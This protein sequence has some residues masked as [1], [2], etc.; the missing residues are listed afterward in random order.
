M[1]KRMMALMFCI[2]AFGFSSAAQTTV[3]TTGGASGYIPVFTGTA[4]ITSSGI[5]YSSGNVGIG[6]TAPAAPLE[7]VANPTSTVPQVR[8]SPLGETGSSTSIPSYLDFYSTFDAYPSDQGPR[9]TATIKAQYSGGTW[10]NEALVFEV[11]TGSVNDA[12]NEPTERMRIAGNGNVGICT[13]APGATLEVNGSAKVDGNVT[14]E[15]GGGITFPD[16]TVQTT[17]YQGT[18]PGS[19]TPPLQVS[20]TEVTV[21]GGVSANGSGLKHVSTNATCDTGGSSGSYNNTC[22]ISVPW[23]G[24][25]F[26]DTNYTVTCTPKGLTNHQAVPVIYI[27]DQDKTTTSVSVTVFSEQGD[28][29]VAGLNCIAIHD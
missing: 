5:T 2:A 29:E 6:T 1:H 23:P 24:T 22:T 26:A 8:I 25:P 17:A 28:G 9:R 19:D 3:T 27:R 4:T 18:A 16:G 20:Q 10:G 7:V 15:G 11:G 21:N 12:A 14:V 13:A